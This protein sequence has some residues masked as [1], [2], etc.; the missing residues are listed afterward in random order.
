M[1]HVS[2]APRETSCA[3][4]VRDD[5]DRDPGSLLSIDATL[6]DAQ[7]YLSKPRRDIDRQGLTSSAESEYFE[8]SN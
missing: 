3:S 8:H 7:R 6:T 1:N 5:G 2:L 4:R